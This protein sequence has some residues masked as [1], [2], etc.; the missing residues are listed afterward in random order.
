MQSSNAFREPSSDPLEALGQVAHLLADV[1]VKVSIGLALGALAARLIRARDLHWSWAL[2]AMAVILL[3][4]PVLAGATP[5]LLTAAL[6]A[7]ARGRRWHREDVE[8]GAD[9]AGLAAARR[10]P[11][12]LLHSLSHAAAG[13]RRRRLSGPAWFRGEDLILGCDRGGRPASIPFGGSRGGTHSLLVGATG[14]G[15]TVTQTWMAV[16]A[17]ERGMSAVVVDPKG[18]RDMRAEVQRA[19]LATGRSF[20][21]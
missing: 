9:L 19:A 10:G 21:E 3:A 13:R 16:R 18:D 17:I 11:L 20:I 2:V 7:V 4:R 6:C 5:P 15:K 14:S 1:A 12:D 8:A